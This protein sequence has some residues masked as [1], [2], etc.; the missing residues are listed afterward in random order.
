ME[1]VFIC[2]RYKRTEN[3]RKL[4]KVWW[5]GRNSPWTF[6]KWQNWSLV[7]YFGWKV[8]IGPWEFIKCHNWPLGG[9]FEGFVKIGPSTLNI[10]SFS[11]WIFQMWKIALIILGVLNHGRNDPWTYKFLKFT[12]YTLYSITFAKLVLVSL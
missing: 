4:S 12:I 2:L 8:N 1:S 9:K 6:R 11:P 7:E 5:I 10:G 3:R